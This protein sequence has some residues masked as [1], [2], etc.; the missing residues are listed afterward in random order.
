MNRRI[1]LNSSDPGFTTWADGAACRQAIRTGSRSFHLASLL[2]PEATRWSAH[3]MYAFCRSAD[4]AIDEAADP[5]AAV[6]GVHHRLNRIYAGDPCD[7]PSDRAFADIVVRFNIPRCVP[8][9][10]LEGFC[11]DAE[12]RRYET[13]GDLVAYS[14]RVASTVGVMMAL[15]MGV[16]HRGVLARACDLGIAMQL[17]NIARDVGEDARAGRLYLPREMM[18]EAGIDPEKWLETPAFSA[19]LAQVT[20]QLLQV[21]QS[22]YERSERGIAALPRNCR[23]AIWAARRIYAAI[24]D[25]V[26]LND[27]NSVDRRAITSA[28]SKLYHLCAAVA[29]ARLEARSHAEPLPNNPPAMEAAFLVDAVTLHPLDTEPEIRLKPLWDYGGWGRDLFDLLDRVEQR[30]RAGSAL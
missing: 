21:A 3:A 4:D 18:R 26:A 2:L 8:D 30:R 17:T 27:Y 14:V 13:L 19:P 11:W 10:L 15:V 22:Y 9:A 20:A 7:L 28:R 5:A 23:A 24:G 1:H 12:G 16:R 25:G 6:A 29:G